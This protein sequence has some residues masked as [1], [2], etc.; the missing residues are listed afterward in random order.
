MSA[1]QGATTGRRQFL[2]AVG[3]GAGSALLASGPLTGPA[4]AERETSDQQRKP[5]YRETEHVRAFYQVNRY[6]TSK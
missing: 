6:P 1:D 4:K 3:V 2:R 5:R